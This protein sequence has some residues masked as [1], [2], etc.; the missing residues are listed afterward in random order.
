MTPRTVVG[1]DGGLA[2][3]DQTHAH[4]HDVVADLRT[5]LAAHRSHYRLN[6]C[7]NADARRDVTLVS[8]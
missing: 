7:T 1:E 5:A 4:E 8:V 6:L 3:L 2:G